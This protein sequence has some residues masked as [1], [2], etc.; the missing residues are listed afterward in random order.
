MVVASWKS[1]LSRP[2]MCGGAIS[3]KYSGTAWPRQA[4]DELCDVLLR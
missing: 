1:W 2:R 4:M 3:L